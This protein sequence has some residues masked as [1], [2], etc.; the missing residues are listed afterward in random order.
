[1]LQAGTVLQ[2]TYRIERPIGK[3]GMGEVYVASHVRLPKQV[4]IK[5]LSSTVVTNEE[6]Y[7]RFRREAEISSS[8][9]HPNIVEVH[10]F[11]LTP[12]GEPYIVMELLEGE[13]LS[14][15]LARE[16]ALSVER[17]LEITRP[18]ASA[19]LAAH[20]RGVVHRDLKPGN[21]FMSTRGGPELVKVLDFG[22]SKI[23]GA[24]DV[25]TRTTSLIGTPAYMSPE[26]ARGKSGAADG[27]ADQFALA[28][29]VYEM[30][31]GKP[32]FARDGDEL[33][34]ILTRIVTED[35]PRLETIPDKLWE[36]LLKALAKEP[37]ARYADVG[38][39]VEALERAV[40]LEPTTLKML[41]PRPR[42]T[43]PVSAFSATT[44]ATPSLSGE[45]AVTVPPPRSARPILLIAAIGGIAIAVAL[46]ITLMHRGPAPTPAT[47]APQPAVPAALPAPAP[48]A[49]APNPVAAT[50]T[51]PAPPT[52][53]P[54]APAPT[55]N[56]AAAEKSE[57]K[58]HE[59]KKDK[60]AKKNG[61][62]YHLEDPFAR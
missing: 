7:A 59:K 8:I 19:L 24:T 12:G 57:L 16:G 5:V 38:A 28:S 36:A 25:K 40:G 61:T 29:M 30:L 44:P 43:P 13:D 14:T 37:D 9:G 47:I 34:T 42:S 11:N 41:T 49:P 18:I 55:E 35:P 15:Q 62:G 60:P 39:F 10:D 53:A 58:K 17:T 33:W 52:A 51:P 46:A 3:G 1:L 23:A 20:G 4:A 31:S 45:K 50:P 21:V 26:Q 22:I 2:E 56:G 27:R 6:A 48:T 32:A 54:P